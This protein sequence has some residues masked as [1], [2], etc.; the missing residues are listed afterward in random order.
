MILWICIRIEIEFP[1]V[2]NATA[3]NDFDYKPLGRLKIKKK[4]ALLQ[5][6]TKTIHDRNTNI[7]RG[8]CRR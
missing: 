1:I 7:E 3:K 5:S 2:S 8:R 6:I 4:K